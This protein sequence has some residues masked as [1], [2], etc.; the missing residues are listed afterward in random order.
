[1]PAS[2]IELSDA[3]RTSVRTR[4][5]ALW[6]ACAL[7]ALHDGYTDSIYVLL[8][9]WQAEF[10]LGYGALAMLRGLYA[11][12][13]AALQV[14]AGRLAEKIDGR[15]V[16][17]LGTAMAGVGYWLAGCSGGAIGL[18][19]ALAVAGAGASTQH[20]IASAAVSRAY[21]AAARTPLSTYNFAGDMGK[22]AIPALVALLLTLTSWRVSLWLLAI[23]AIA[24]A[25]AVALLMPPA[26]PASRPA[27]A[28]VPAGSGRGGFP[29]LLSI[30]LLDS[31]V[32]MGLLTFLPFLLQAKGASLPTVGLALSLVFMGGG[33][34][35]IACGWLGARIGVLRTVI[36]TEG[37]TA[38]GIFAVLVLPLLPCLIMLP[39]LGLMLNGTSSVLYGTVPELAPPGRTERAFALFYTGTIGSGAISPVLYGML[40]DAVGI[41]WAVTVTA[42]AALMTL[43]FALALAPR[44]KGPAC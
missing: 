7:H 9:V 14:P 16:L 23:P 30:G 5:R 1:M 38:I 12:V 27:E 8:P 32:R 18:C 41:N 44:L 26:P 24:V 39:L 42:L 37:G 40:G 34:G 36:L 20:P 4:R 10:A 3:T 22:A 28:H 15:F 2:T 43:P 11:G 29:L 21:G 6:S 19:A 35:K 25:V 17:A 33:A 31:G 13:M